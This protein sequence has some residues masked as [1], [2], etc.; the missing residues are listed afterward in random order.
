M[1][2]TFN[3]LLDPP[4]AAVAFPPPEP[5]QAAR[6]S[7]AVT[8]EVTSA[9]LVKFTRTFL[10][11]HAPLERAGNCRRRVCAGFGLSLVSPRSAAV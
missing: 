11:S 2:Q 9:H 7:A 3:D 4:L 1:I 10:L 5:P 8:I 6:A